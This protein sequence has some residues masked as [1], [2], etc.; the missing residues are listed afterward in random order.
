MIINY[1]PANLSS[2]KQNSQNFFRSVDMCV[3]PQS[4]PFLVC[5]CCLLFAGSLGV[6][7]KV[8]SDVDME[9]ELEGSESFLTSVQY[10]TVAEYLRDTYKLATPFPHIYFDKMFPSAIT[11]RSSEEFPHHLAMPQLAEGWG[12]WKDPNPQQYKKYFLRDEEKMGPGTRSL[13]EHMRS[14]MFVSFLESLTGIPYLLPDP[15][16]HGAGLHQI[17]RGGFLSIHADFNRRESDGL[18]RRVNV[19]MFLNDGWDESWGGHLEFWDG[20]MTRCHEKVLPLLNRL[21]IFSSAKDTMHGHP[22]PLM[23]PFDRYRQSIALYYYTVA[24]P[25]NSDINDQFVNTN[26]QPRPVKD[27]SGGEF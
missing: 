24:P 25:P 11:K 27:R 7:V 4:V 20:N 9:V 15:Y 13:I 12:V 21:L 18:F 22:D 26:F 17:S 1:D 6:V 8:N 10:Q 23:C 2:E 3:L 5:L 16:L 19:F 14:R